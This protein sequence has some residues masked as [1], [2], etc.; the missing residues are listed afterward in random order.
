MAINRQAIIDEILHGGEQAAYSILPPSLAFSQN[1]HFEDGNYELARKLFKE[2]LEEQGLT[3]DKLPRLTITCFD[4]EIHEAIAAAVAKQWKEV[5]DLDFQVKSY[6]WEHFMQ[7]CLRHDFHIMSTTWYSWFNDPLYNLEHMK[8]EN[9][10]MNTTRWQNNKYIELLDQAELSLDFRE[11]KKLLQEAE[12]LIME[13]MPIIPVFYYTFKY[14]KK[15]RV[16]N[17]FL[18]HLGQIDFKWAYINKS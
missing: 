1:A 14:M 3:K 5:L 2:G 15:A 16:N 4:Q 13:E 8:Y 7:K 9:G 18:S 10:D 17:I 12:G 6:K 11:R